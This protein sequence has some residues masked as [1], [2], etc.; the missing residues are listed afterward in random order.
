MK[1]LSKG[2]GVVGFRERIHFEG[3]KGG[4]GIRIGIYSLIVL[5]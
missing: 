5:A 3:A 4:M 1:G 2:R